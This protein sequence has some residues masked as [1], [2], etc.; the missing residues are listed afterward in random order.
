MANQAAQEVNFAGWL[1]NLH[2][3]KQILARNVLVV[4][5]D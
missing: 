4:A 2:R 5:V 1:S 3:T